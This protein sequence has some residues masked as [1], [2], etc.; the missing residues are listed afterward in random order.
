MKCFGGKQ[1]EKTWF[2]IGGGLNVLFGLLHIWLG[3]EFHHATHLSPDYRTLL[4]VQRGRDTRCLLFCLRIIFLQKGAANDR[5][6]QIRSRSDSA[7]LPVA[8]RRRGNP[9]SRVLGVH[10]CDLFA[11]RRSVPGGGSLERRF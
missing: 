6:G 9:I 10:L 11:R 8:S 2:V 3:W 4:D 5:T 7:D 1:N